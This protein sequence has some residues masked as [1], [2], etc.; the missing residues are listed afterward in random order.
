V[1]SFELINPATRS[2]NF[3]GLCALGIMTKAPEPG[4]VKTRLTP[5][6]TANEAAELN[7]CFLRDLSRSI[8]AA[9]KQAAAR[10]VAIYTPVGKES[11][12]RDTLPAEFLL[13]PQ[14]EGNFGERLEQAVSDLLAAGFAAVDFG[15]G[16][17]G[18]TGTF[19]VAIMGEGLSRGRAAFF[20]AA[21]F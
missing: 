14:R 8:D 5:P 6:L 13:I 19:D 9:R 4:K 2:E 12:Y 17:F 11:A 18:F 10:G 3:R 21:N 1:T 15:A 16:L 20:W 7:I